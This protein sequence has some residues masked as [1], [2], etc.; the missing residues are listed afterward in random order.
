MA[1]YPPPYPPPGVPPG[2]P[3]GYDPRQQ[4]RILREQTRAHL[5]AMQATNRAQRNLYRQQSRA[6]RRSS[7]LGPLIVIG[8][9]VAFLL[10]RMRSVSFARFAVW[11]A[12]WWPM[13]LV[14]AGVILLIEWAVDQHLSTTRG[15]PVRRGIGAGTVFLLI[16]LALTGAS[17]GAFHIHRDFL[18][19]NFSI[20]PDNIGEFIGERHDRQQQLDGTVPTGGTVEINDPHGDVTVTGASSDGQIHVTV[21]KQIYSLSDSDADNKDRDLTA[22]MNLVGQTLKIAVPSSTGS[23]TDLTVSLPDSSQTIVNAGRGAVTISAMNAPVNV[24]SDHGDIDVQNI[25][26]SVVAHLNSSSSSFHAKQIQGQVQLKGRG[27]D[28]TVADASGPVTLDGEFYGD[29]H[30]EHLRG[31]LDFK[32]DRTQFSL[33]RL[34]GEI[35][36]SPSSELTGSEISGPTILHT[37]NRNISLDRVAGDL[38]V[39]NSNGHV[40]LTSALPLGNVS[41]ENHNGRVELTLPEKAGFALTATAQGG[42]IENDLGL[43]ATTQGEQQ[44]LT[45]KRGNSA[46]NITV[47]TTTADISL[48]E[49]AAV[50]LPGEPPAPSTPP[51]MSTRKSSKAPSNTNLKT[52]AF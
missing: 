9:G 34:D 28:I 23:S 42:T 51:V 4:G 16:L 37:R 5:R 48:H 47:R 32:T 45:G 40:T 14:L 30:L 49:G 31:G 10:T 27:E 35:D 29:T 2:A 50:T 17:I 19:N 18:Y 52:Q 38:F 46:A 24:S 41:V 11:F 8:I 25:A 6:L 33:G 43:A 26:G 13:L 36:I 20:N 21:N 39:I 44:T 1:G 3:F 12:H 22:T 7:I 15:V